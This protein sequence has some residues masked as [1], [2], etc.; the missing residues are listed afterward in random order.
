MSFLQKKV[1]PNVIELTYT[2]SESLKLI[3]PTVYIF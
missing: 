1:T 3:D 2:K